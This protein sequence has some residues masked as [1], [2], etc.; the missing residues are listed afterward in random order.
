[1]ATSRIIDIIVYKV[2]TTLGERVRRKRPELW[3]ND[4]CRIKS[5]RRFIMPKVERQCYDNPSYS[6]DLVPCDFWLFP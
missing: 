3:E 6:P 4:C 5:M 1:M 2:L